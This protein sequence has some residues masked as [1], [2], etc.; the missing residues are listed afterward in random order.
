MIHIDIRN[1]E[2]LVFSPDEFNSE[3]KTEYL[4]HIQSYALCNENY[5]LM[6]DFLENLETEIM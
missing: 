1:I 6:K 2:K 5:E 3:Q 4:E